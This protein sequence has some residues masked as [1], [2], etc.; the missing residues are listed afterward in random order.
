M[1]QLLIS[2]DRWFSRVDPGAHRRIKGL[3]LVTAFGLAAL[4]ATVPQI[5]QQRGTSLG[6]LAAGF[7]L[8]ASVSE[9]RTTRYQSACDLVL[10]CIAAGVGAASF[11]VLA[12]LLGSGWSELTLISGSF[13]AGFLRKFGIRGTG[14]G[15]QL[16]IGQLLAHNVGAKSV[17][18]GAI[19]LAV[20]LAILGSVVPRMLSGPA[21]QPA[22]TSPPSATRRG[23]L[24]ATSELLMGAQAAIAS[25]S[26]VI[27]GHFTG[28]TESAW[29]ITATTYVVADS[30]RG[31]I[32]R[33]YRRIVGTSIGVPLAIALLPFAA[34]APLGLWLAAAT[35]M[36]IYA[37]A[38][39]KNYDIASGA[40]AFALIVTM[41]A[42][43]EHSVGILLAR[44]WETVI[45]GALGL[46]VLLLLAPISLRKRSDAARTQ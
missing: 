13:C 11:V 32:D 33:V 44:L 25:A 12:P 2:I 21:E 16:F 34:Q 24:A 8:W 43:G 36:I 31:T 14:I 45:G 18:V 15:S 29:A 9:G 46:T 28:L 37:I 40:Y 41:A 27:L 20:A 6:P 22:V 3:R 17:D 38:L 26:I 23:G 35:A 19:V 4:L 42:S 1:Q 39:P 7:A 5:A 10:L 30:T